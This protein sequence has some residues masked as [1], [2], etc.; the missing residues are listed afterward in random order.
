MRWSSPALHDPC[1]IDG[2]KIKIYE[3]VEGGWMFDIWLNE[4]ADE[5][6]E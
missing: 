3:A 1:T 6:E 2:M 5:D 4:E